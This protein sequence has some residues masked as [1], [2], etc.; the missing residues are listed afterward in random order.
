MSIAYDTDFY[1]WVNEQARL[2]KSGALSQLDVE[3]LI[4]EMESMGRSEL[5]QLNNRFRVLIAHLLKWEFQP[6]HR[7]KSWELTIKEQRRAI[8]RLVQGSPSLKNPMG[9]DDFLEWA[10][11]SAVFDAARETDMLDSEF[12]A[13]P[14]WTLDKIL[15]PNFL[16]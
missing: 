8:A 3:N 11:E 4:E 1:G 5:S 7:G 16:P 14:I 12:P 10:W 13:T 6:S 15:D 9:K 2:L